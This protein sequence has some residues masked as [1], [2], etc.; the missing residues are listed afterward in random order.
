[1]GDGT[2]EEAEAGALVAEADALMAEVDALMAEGEGAEEAVPMGEV[3]VKG[4]DEEVGGV[5]V[6]LGEEGAVVEEERNGG[7]EFSALRLASRNEAIPT[8]PPSLV[9]ARLKI[10]VFTTTHHPQVA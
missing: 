5:V 2:R 9:R 1:M 8:P 6:V 10:V 7:N 4:V 3:E